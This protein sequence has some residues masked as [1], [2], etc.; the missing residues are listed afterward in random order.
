MVC[1]PEGETGD[2]KAIIR[3]VRGGKGAANKLPRAVEPPSVS[4]DKL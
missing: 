2:V 3:R 1:G 4:D